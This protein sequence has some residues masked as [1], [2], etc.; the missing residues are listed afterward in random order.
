MPTRA[1]FI[2]AGSAAALGLATVTAI[3]AAPADDT[4][5]VPPEQLVQR[6]V[7]GNKRFVDG[8]MLNAGTHAERREAL[9]DSQAP[10]CGIVSCA[11]SRVP[12]ELVFDQTIGDLFVTR[13][14]G[15][16][17]PDDILG[18]LEYAIDHLGTRLIVVLG[19]EQCGAVKAVYDASKS[20]SDLPGHL[21]V[22]QR[23]LQ[24]A[25]A[26]LADQGAPLAD[27]VRANVRAVV[28]RVQAAGPS[29]APAVSKNTVHVVGAVYHLD[30][31][32]V[33]FLARG[34]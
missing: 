21:D 20:H 23:A 31:G 5:T 29:I 27:A 26:P 32:R 18:S 4:T 19:H 3:D 24:P 28:A 1:T 8:K 2:G 10:F 11:D 16:Y 30:T 6:L 13:V 15:N 33:E 34:A 14:A 7:D 12:P 9:T 17:A 22:I 25:I